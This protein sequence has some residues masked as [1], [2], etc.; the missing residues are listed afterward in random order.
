MP[1]LDRAETLED[2][3]EGHVAA[4]QLRRLIEGDEELRAVRVG[5][6]GGHGE[7]AGAAVPQLEILVV[8]HKVLTAGGVLA[9]DG[10][11]ALA[12]LDQAQVEALRGVIRGADDVRALEK[13]A[14]L[15]GEA[16]V[17]AVEVDPL[18]HAEV[19]HGAEVLR[20]HGAH[21]RLELERHRAHIRLADAH[22]KLHHG[23]GRVDGPWRAIVHLG[24]LDGVR[25][26]AQAVLPA[27]R[28]RRLR[29]EVLG[30]VHPPRL[31]VL[32]R[33]TQAEDPQMHRR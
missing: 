9:V 18:E 5:R 17:D 4:V 25:R 14:R 10:S 31:V 8:K 32:H 6:V 2:L 13:V 24:H 21:V 28:V 30:G 7:H 1:Y 16:R 20:R 11:P 23:V 3:P 33:P 19:D 27:H 15:A 12:V 22:V 26:V 29:R